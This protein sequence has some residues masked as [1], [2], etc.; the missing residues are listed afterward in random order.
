[1]E[2]SPFPFGR[3][4]LP[5]QVRRH[6][7]DLPRLLFDGLAFF[8]DRTGDQ[9]L[10]GRLL[11]RYPFA[12]HLELLEHGLRFG[13]FPFEGLTLGLQPFLALL[14]GLRPRFEF[15]LGRVEPMFSLFE[16][17]SGP[18]HFPQF[19]LLCLQEGL[20]LGHAIIHLAALRLCRLLRVL[21]EAHRLR[22]DVGGVLF[23]LRERGH[24]RFEFLRAFRGLDPHPVQL[25]LFSG[26]STGFRREVLLGPLHLLF[27]AIQSGHFL[28]QALRGLARFDLPFLQC[29]FDGVQAILPLRQCGLSVFEPGGGL[30]QVGEFLLELP[31]PA[32]KPGLP[33]LNRLL[34]RRRSLFSR[35]DRLEAL[36]QFLRVGS[37]LL[38]EV[39][40]GRSGPCELLLSGHDPMGLRGLLSRGRLLLFLFG[41]EIPLRGSKSIL[42]A[43]QI[44]SALPQPRLEF[45]QGRFLLRQG[46]RSR[47]ERRLPS[48][49]LV[50]RTSQFLSLPPQGGLVRHELFLLGLHDRKD[51]SRLFVFGPRIRLALLHLPIRG[52]LP[53][54]PFLLGRGEGPL[55]LRQVGLHRREGLFSLRD[56]RLASCELATGTL[57]R[58]RFRGQLEACRVEIFSGS[59]RFLS[60]PIER[61]L[62][63]SDLG[64]GL[65]QSGLSFLEVRL[66][67][68]QRFFAS[69]DR[70]GPSVHF[71]QGGLVRFGGGSERL[72][73]FVEVARLAF[74]SCLRLRGLRNLLLER[75]LIRPQLFVRVG[76][77]R[78]GFL[79]L[80]RSSSELLLPRL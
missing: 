33:A 31:L 50:L 2:A 44:L 63:L 13:P 77:G 1:M 38:L 71:G 53:P 16:V 34:L 62:S 65:R 42:F 3:L 32:G 64:M 48:T 6:R 68:R 39:L 26:E 78:A 41:I 61:G 24:L 79:E 51:P 55:T 70:H 8:Q 54:F 29:R 15:G 25:R 4:V 52:G 20:L 11:L 14:D 49:G 58:L 22:L 69:F 76:Q 60:G 56:G 80:P 17:L 46:L 74:E 5:L 72:L 73:P 35:R 67:R 7:P 10:D 21:E 47:I 27:P 36:R 28:L 18:G 12:L 66:R 23:S 75:R 59:L 40:L 19:L 43:T 57:D 9:G 45:V 37:D 30:R